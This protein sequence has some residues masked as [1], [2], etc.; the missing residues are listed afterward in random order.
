MVKK[1]H[2]SRLAEVLHEKKGPSARDIDQEVESAVQAIKETEIEI[3]KAED[4]LDGGWGEAGD[5]V[6]IINWSASSRCSVGARDD[7]RMH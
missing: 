5:R 3:L 1:S 4:M 7:C 6:H 2:L